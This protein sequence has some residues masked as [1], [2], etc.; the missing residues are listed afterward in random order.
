[1]ER[2]GTGRLITL[3]AEFDTVL[4]HCQKDFGVENVMVTEDK[5]I[6]IPKS[7]RRWAPRLVP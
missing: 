4:A 7:K 5:T 2:Q 6:V 1:M 3:S